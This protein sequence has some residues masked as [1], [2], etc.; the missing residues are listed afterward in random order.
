MKLSGGIR[1]IFDSVSDA[2]VLLDDSGGVSYMNPEARRLTGWE[3]EEALGMD[4]WEVCRMLDRRTGTPV[5]NGMGEALARDGCF[6]LPSSTVLL[7]RQGAEVLVSGTVYLSDGTA[8][9]SG[10]VEGMV[11][12]DLS[13]RWLLDPALRRGQK[14]DALRLLARG[15]TSNVNDL[16][17][18]LNARLTSIGREQNDRSA[19]LRHIRDSRKVIG[20]IGGMLASLSAG[21]GTSTGPEISSAPGVIADCAG[22]FAS[23]YPD[24]ELELAY[25]DRTG[26]AAVPPGLL[27]QVV[28]NLLMN[29]GEASGSGGSVRLAACRISVY[30]DGLQV[31][32]GSYVLVSVS[33]SGPGIAEDD[34]S[35]IFNP[36]FTTGRSRYGLGLPAVYTIVS[37][38]G[39]YVTV[40]SRLGGGARFSVY[41]PSA[42]GVQTETLD[43]AIPSVV[44]RGLGAE[45]SGDVR[46]MLEAIGC[47][48][49]S[50]EKI[51]GESSPAEEGTS[52]G[53]SYTIL[54]TDYDHFTTEGD[55]AGF[56]AKAP[57]GRIVLLDRKL[58]SAEGH[59]PGTVFLDSPPSL[60]RIACA[61]SGLAW[62]R[63]PVSGSGCEK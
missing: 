42:G 5:Q 44:I 35:R 61:V 50:E 4:L 59:A 3:P 29:A 23:A 40:D 8:M 62:R 16:L 48:V 63:T 57:D 54:L 2:V 7:S 32:Q 53:E 39:G 1:G 20:R 49:L 47:S 51:R 11:F 27:E 14:A 36:F 41:V 18:V 46:T 12:R 6:N 38:F 25:P 26:F 21:H 15:I 55:P 45:Q 37:S 43:D 56:R 10:S 19:V 58:R 52:S 33:D 34:L 60:D 13:A 30:Q 24:V 22:L 31:P 17:T 9:G 28:L